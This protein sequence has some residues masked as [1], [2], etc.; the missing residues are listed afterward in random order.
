[1]VEPPSLFLTRRNPGLPRCRIIPRKSG[2][3]DL[4]RGREPCGTAH[5]IR[6]DAL[7]SP[8]HALAS[9]KLAE[10]ERELSFWPEIAQDVSATL[11]TIFSALLVVAMLARAEPVRNR[12][13][14]RMA[15]IKK[16]LA[17]EESDRGSEARKG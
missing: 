14:A 2:K 1:M 5:R 17:G 7:I 13:V 11:V 12:L 10:R 9:E 6:D 8:E 15:K 3:P 4:R 16:R